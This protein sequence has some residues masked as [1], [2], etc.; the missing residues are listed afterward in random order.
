MDVSWNAVGSLLAVD[1]LDPDLV[2]VLSLPLVRTDGETCGLLLASLLVVTMRSADVPRLDTD[3]FAFRQMDGVTFQPGQQPASFLVQ[4]LPVESDDGEMVG[5]LTFSS[6][7]TPLRPLLE[8]G[9][10]AIAN[11]ARLVSTEKAAGTLA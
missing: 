3:A 8:S 7:N 6:P 9:F 4:T 1:A 10:A 2:A 5:L 11:D